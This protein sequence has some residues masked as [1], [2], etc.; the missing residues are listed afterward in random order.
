M[1]NIGLVLLLIFVTTVFA[2]IFETN[3]VKTTQWK[4]ETDEFGSSFDTT[5]LI[6]NDS[7]IKVDFELARKKGENDWPYVELI[8][9]LGKNMSSTKTILVTYKCTRP[10]IVKLSQSDFSWKGDK[11]YAHFQY[12]MV[13]SDK[14]KTQLLTVANFRQP[15][16][17]PLESVKIPLKLENVDAIYF[18][19]SLDD[20]VGGSATIEIKE[21]ILSK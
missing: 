6:V 5:N 18:T 21:M 20:A 10:V 17:A 7:L 11:S 2:T 9:S 12:K 8:C 14:W 13:A 19:P 3:L 1:K 4:A 16:W 15:R